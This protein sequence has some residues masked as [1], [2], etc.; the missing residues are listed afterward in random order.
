LYDSLLGQALAMSA[1]E[2]IAV[3]LA[4][5]YLVLVIRENIWCWVCAAV[6]SGIYVWLFIGAKLYMESLLYLFYVV[7]AA[8]GWF[9]WTRGGNKDDRLPI[10]R[11]SAKIHLLAVGAVVLLATVTG[12]TL[13]NY[14]DAAYPYIDSATTFSAIW[15]TY[16]VARKVF[17]NWWYWLLIDVVSIFV[18]W[19]RDLEFTAVLFVLYV[20][21]IPVGMRQWRQSMR[22]QADAVQN[23]ARSA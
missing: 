9:V 20:F 2:I 12:W 17:E 15:A 5:A 11:Y 3:V 8:Y 4:V 10:I 22:S 23:F 1:I 7:M 13:S 14:S 16:L 19:A 21:L 18:Y 6:S